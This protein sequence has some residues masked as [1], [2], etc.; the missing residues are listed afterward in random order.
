MIMQTLFKDMIFLLV[1]KIFEIHVLPKQNLSRYLP[2]RD[3]NNAWWNI[4]FKVI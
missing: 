1:E 2:Q 4:G 3:K